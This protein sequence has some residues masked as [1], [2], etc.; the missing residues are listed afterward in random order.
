MKTKK[1]FST[2]S[3]KPVDVEYRLRRAKES[4]EAALTFINAIDPTAFERLDVHRDMA[5]SVYQL[6]SA[7]GVAIE[8][9]PVKKK[10]ASAAR[11]LEQAAE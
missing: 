1:S 4:A 10:R 9:A 2:P 11:D 5:A 3:A 8:V 6:I 7:L